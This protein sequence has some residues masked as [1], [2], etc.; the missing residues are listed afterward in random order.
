MSCI[1]KRYNLPLF[2]E[3]CRKNDIDGKEV[4]AEISGVQLKLIVASTPQSQMKGYSDSKASPS[5][6]NGMLFIYNDDQPL[7]FWMKGVKFGLDIIFFDS[8]MQ[9]I[10]HHTME[11]GHEVEEKNLPKYQSK[12]PARFAVELP[13]GWCEKN[14]DSDCKLSF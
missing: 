12:K 11:P 2:E 4:D 1:I 8:T 3:Y 7:S 10:D 5:G 6:D 13:S 9:Y 14:M